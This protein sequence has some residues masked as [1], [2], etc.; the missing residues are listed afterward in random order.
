MCPEGPLPFHGKGHDGALAGAELL[1]L[2]LEDIA[3][4]PFDQA[5]Q[6]VGIHGA[7]RL[8]VGKHGLD[9]R[10]RSGFPVAVSAQSVRHHK[11]AAVPVHLSPDGVLVF[12]SSSENRNR[13]VGIPFC[14]MYTRFCRRFG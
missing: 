11:Q 4:G 2:H 10:L 8:P 5:A 6:P 1:L 12:R 14:M 9:G 7:R 13:S 3:V